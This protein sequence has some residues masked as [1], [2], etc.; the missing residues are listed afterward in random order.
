MWDG[1]E[2]LHLFVFWKL[3]V[4]SPSAKAAGIN[5]GD[6]L[7]AGNYEHDPCTLS[8]RWDNRGRVWTAWIQ[9]HKVLPSKSNNKNSTK[10][11]SRKRYQ[12]NA[13]E[14]VERTSAGPTSDTTPV[15]TQMAG[16]EEEIRL[17][18]D[19][20]WGG[21]MSRTSAQDEAGFASG[22]I[23]AAGRKPC[24]RILGWRTLLRLS[25][26]TFMLNTVFCGNMEKHTRCSD[27]CWH[28]G[29]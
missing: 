11:F 25:R 28:T 18:D 21:W 3:L 14:D 7:L 1:R 4:P 15:D 13:L 9:I 20:M 16:A 22:G 19:W 17:R 24:G 27:C 5:Q 23:P 10:Q 26:S 29:D 6:N 2:V 12:N 8:G